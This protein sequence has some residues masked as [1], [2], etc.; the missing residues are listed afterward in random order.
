M[1]RIA[2]FRAEISNSKG[3][4]TRLAHHNARVT[5]NDCNYGC[6]ISAYG[7]KEGAKHMTL[8]FRPVSY[9]SAAGAS[10]GLSFAH[11][12]LDAADIADLE[13][14]KARLAIIRD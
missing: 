13:S 8:D 7:D 9:I 3:S 5:L 10:Y 11:L 6:T 2:H 4:V 12:N 1:A 14:G